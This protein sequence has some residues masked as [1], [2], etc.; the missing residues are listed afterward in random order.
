MY[1]AKAHESSR[2][3]FYDP[4]LHHGLRRRRKLVAELERAVDRDE[5]EVHFQPVVSLADHSLHAFEV[6]A[7]WEHPTRGLLAATEFVG[8]AE[9]T[10]LIRELAALVQ[11]KAFAAAAT[12]QDEDVGL[13]LN[14]SPRELMSETLVPDLASGL[15]RAGLDPGRV[16]LE[17]TESSVIQDERG[18][19][20]AMHHL[21][22]LGLQLSIDDFGTGYSSLAR[23]DEFPIQMLKVPQLFVDKLAQERPDTSVVAT[24]IQLAGWLGVP[25]VG[26]GIEE[27]SQARTLRALGCRYG[28]GYLFSPPLTE[29]EVVEY[30]APAVVV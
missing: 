5:F 7:R 28:Q 14:L 15:S 11:T 8:L 25:T 19:L 27:A 3:A 9:E 30:L 21:R 6:L 22:E 23:L 29:A 18:A 4:T 24:I 2:H 20:R 26:E 13:W 12:W 17:I 16:T 10:G 1:T